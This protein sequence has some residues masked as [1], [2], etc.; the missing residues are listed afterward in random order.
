MGKLRPVI[1]RSVSTKQPTHTRVYPNERSIDD[2]SDS[3]TKIE[4]MQSTRSSRTLKL[5]DKTQVERAVAAHT[6]S[7]Q[8]VHGL[9]DT[10]TASEQNRVATEVLT[11]EMD[12]GPV[13]AEPLR[14]AP[15]KLECPAPV[16]SAAAVF[17]PNAEL[18]ADITDD[19]AAAKRHA[20]TAA[21]ATFNAGTGAA[22][23]DANAGMRIAQSINKLIRE[24]VSQDQSLVREVDGE[25]DANGFSAMLPHAIPNT[26]NPFDFAFVRKHLERCPNDAV[27]ACL[28]PELEQ[29][30]RS[31]M[32]VNRRKHE[33]LMLRTPGE[34][35]LPCVAGSEC[36]GRRIMCVN[37]GETLMAFFSEQEW[38]AY[39]SDLQSW[40]E[41]GREKPV[42]PNTNTRCLLC[43][44]AD[45]ATY[46]MQC[47]IRGVQFRVFDF[48]ASKKTNK[49]PFTVSKYCNL[50]NT[51]GEYR[52][53]DCIGQSTEG[54]RGIVAP[55]VRADLIAFERYEDKVS[56]TTHFRQ[57]LPYPEEIGDDASESDGLVDDKPVGF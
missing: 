30:M 23:L 5:S 12:V 38:I 52:I 16:E 47:R 15:T 2:E 24:K 40:R 20:R 7:V 32:T 17:A 35:E 26:L 21:A 49:I 51:R 14:L 29:I 41:G 44:R 13:P 28:T 3:M 6:A 25:A 34:H 22:S 31:K 48:D 18:P 53:E 50:V 37:G 46:V 57:L 33:E 43:L 39:Q 36:M 9:T 4:R 1:R 42:P 54:Y 19:Y 11:R 10:A 56:N 45:A 8:A 55:M 27:Q